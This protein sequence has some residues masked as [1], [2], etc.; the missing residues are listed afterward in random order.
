MIRESRKC[1]LKIVAT[2]CDQGAT[3]RAAINA[4]LKE[5]REYCL[6]N[7]TEKS[8]QGYLIDDEEVV[9]LYDVP[10]L[11]K[12]M[13]NN[14]LNKNLH[15][16]SDGTEKVASWSHVVQLYKI[17]LIHGEFYSQFYKY[18]DEHIIPSKI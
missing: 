11:M 5:T 1:G 14:L 3:N 6:N 17:Y 8:Y 18:S 13:E 16:T 15:Y 12:C 9:H 2:V 4:L 10:H 7:N